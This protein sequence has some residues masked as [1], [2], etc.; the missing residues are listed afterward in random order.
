VITIVLLSYTGDVDAVRAAHVAW[1]R[2]SLAAGRLITAGRSP[3]SGGVLVAKG[4][5]AEVEA[6]W[7]NDPYNVAGVATAKFVA[8]TPSMAA[9]GLESLLP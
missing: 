2:E 1:L 7:Q 4:D 9:P 5:L 3:E 6:W 8:F